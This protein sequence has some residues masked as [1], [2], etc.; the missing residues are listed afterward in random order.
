MKT[1][2]LFYRIFLNQPDLIAELIPGIP[3][4][5]EFEYSAPVLKEKETRL[6]GL[7]TPISNNSDVPLIFLEAQMQRDIKFYSRYFRGI[8]SYIDQYEISKNWRGLLILLNKRLEL[9][10]EL[11]HRN[12]LNS[13]VERLY[14]ED[15]L[16]QDDLSPNLALLRL[17]VTPKD[18]AGLAARKILNSVSTE[19]E[20]QLKLDLVE[21]I[22]VN[23]FTQLTLKEIQKMLNLKEADV[24]QTRFYQEVL[25]IG[26]KKGLQQ[27]LQQGEANLTIRQLKRRC[28]NLTAIQEQKVR[29]LTIPE[30]ESL[31]EALLDF[32]NM[33]DLENWLQ[34]NRR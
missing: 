4:D 13:Q 29:S 7:L 14:L 9:G 10:S 8:F 34:D 21:S 23:K 28:G 20:F 18:Q 15:L 6:D 24:T 25:E 16:H 31:G 19:A 3:S 12:L 32:Q 5:C 1:D 22:L 26:E 33:S 27:G 30:L 17:I 2:K 11:P